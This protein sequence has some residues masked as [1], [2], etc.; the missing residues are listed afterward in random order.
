MTRRT[1]S[2]VLKC[3]AACDAAYSSRRD[4]R[5]GK[6][7]GG[8]RATL[9]KGRIR[10]SASAY[11]VSAAYNLTQMVRLVHGSRREAGPTGRTP[12]HRPSIPRCL[13]RYKRQ[14]GM[15]TGDSAILQQP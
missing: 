12:G 7:V 8:L 11:E 3:S 6:A 1:A 13:S 10:T 14:D 9:F 15:K 2:R 5:L 4:L